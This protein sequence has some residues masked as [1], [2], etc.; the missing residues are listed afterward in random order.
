VGVT[1]SSPLLSFPWTLGQ[2]LL[3]RLHGWVDPI[4][5]R[6]SPESYCWTHLSSTGTSA[7]PIPLVKLIR[8]RG[9]LQTDLQ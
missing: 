8:D 4:R 7:V 1:L 9:M 3:S 6:C 2:K 5:L